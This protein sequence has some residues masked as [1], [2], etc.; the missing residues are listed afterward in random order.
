MSINLFTQVLQKSREARQGIFMAGLV[1][2]FPDLETCFEIAKTI[3]EAG[4]DILELSASFSDPVADGPTLQQAYQHVLKSAFEDVCKN[5]GYNPDVY[6]T[7]Y[8]DRKERA[9]GKSGKQLD[10]ITRAHLITHFF[11]LG[12]IKFN[13]ADMMQQILI[14][15][16]RLFPTGEHDDTVDA[17][18][19]CLWEIDRVLQH[20]DRNKS[21]K[22]QTRWDSESGEPIYIGPNYL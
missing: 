13:H 14:D 8:R 4:A 15:D 9:D 22:I 10:K 2:G 1:P 16:L 3:I 5:A 17:L 19:G 21:P 12:W 7:D 20:L 11:E 6:E 18:V